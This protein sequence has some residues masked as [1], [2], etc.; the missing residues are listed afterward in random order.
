MMKTGENEGDFYCFRG[1]K[2]TG[3]TMNF[4]ATY[5][6]GL[7]CTPISEKIAKDLA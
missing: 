4:I 2:V 1:K 5:G 7:I 3:E 6:K